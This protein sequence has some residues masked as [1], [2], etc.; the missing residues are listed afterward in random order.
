M[1]NRAQS[2][3]EGA[4]ALPSVL[5]MATQPPFLARRQAGQDWLLSCCTSNRT[6]VVRAWEAEQ[7]AP[8]YGGTNWRAV[9][10]PLMRSVEA[11]KGMGAALGPVLAD[12]SSDQAWWL[13]SPDVDDILDDIRQLRVF[14]AD[15]PLLCP[16]VLYPV[17]ERV[18]LE[19]PDGR[20]R[21]TDPIRL[22]AAF[23]PG[24]FRIP[25]E[26]FV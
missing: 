2:I 18:W 4:I 13:V 20:G 8:I 24:G 9:Q 5:V 16:P 1:R 23:G 3:T 22:G 17:G 26:A 14:G 25:T 19:R 12:V 15:W 10:A 6:A 11:M 7:L 21:L